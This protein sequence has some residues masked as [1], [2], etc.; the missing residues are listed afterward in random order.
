MQ[1]ILNILISGVFGVFLCCVCIGECRISDCLKVTL[2]HGGGIIGRY[3][4]SFRGR[5]IRAFMGIP[6]AEPPIGKLRFRNPVAKTPWSGYLE[7]VSNEAM[8]PQLNDA[9]R[10]EVIG[11]EDCLYLNV[12]V[13]QFPNRTNHL[14]VMVY[15]HGGGF[16]E[17]SAQFYE[18]DFFLDHDVILV[19][20]TYRLGALGFLSTNTSDSPGN[21]GLKDQVEIL[22]W[23]QQNIQAFGGNPEQV[24]I[25]GES[26]GAA[27]VTYLM[28]SSLAN[29]LFHRA[30]A[31]SGTLYAP[32]AFVNTTKALE[33]TKTFSQA[34]RCERSRH[35]NWSRVIECL[36]HKPVEKIF[37]A[38]SSLPKWNDMPLIDFAPS[39]EKDRE[40]AFITSHPQTLEVNHGHKIPLLIGINSEEGAL[41]S[42]SILGKPRLIP[43]LEDRWEKIL[44]QIL[45][46]DKF[47]LAYRSNITQRINDFYFKGQKG[48]QAIEMTQNFTNMF[49]DFLL[50]NGFNK[51]LEKRFQ[52]PN[53]HAETFVYLFSHRGEGSFTDVIGGPNNKDYGVAHVDDLLY[54]FPH[55]DKE[56][57]R[58]APTKEDIFIQETLVKLWVNFATFRDPTYMENLNVTW[59]PADKFPLDYFRIGNYK[60]PNQPLFAMERGLWTQR[61]QFLDN[62]F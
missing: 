62:V 42:A 18:P 23:V 40:G 8:C 35:L 10:F 30:I 39:L 45:F 19:I 22:K 9:G 4:R 51:Y 16:K 1:I 52:K 12:Y 53:E 61:Q 33:L 28:S 43:E 47:D 13:P 36:Q 21:F 60:N 58:A 27:S 20:G 56:F 5:G 38:T 54:L 55:F 32:W 41:A 11:K 7:T 59:T 3:L 49:T 44:S 15:F 46:Y 25:F 24:T 31:Q 37:E 57:F 34:L 2:P 17:G 26:A 48:R 50:F 6:Y 29:G 14:P